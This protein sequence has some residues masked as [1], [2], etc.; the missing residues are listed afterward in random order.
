VEEAVKDELSPDEMAQLESSHSTPDEITP[1]QMA[2][3]D[4][5]HAAHP[6]ELT[7]EQ[8][9]QLSPDQPAPSDKPGEI[10][11]VHKAYDYLFKPEDGSTPVPEM[12][13]HAASLGF[14]KLVDGAKSISPADVVT[15]FITG[16]SDKIKDSMG[17][18]DGAATALMLP[19]TA[20][21]QQMMEQAFP[22][23]KNKAGLYADE[24]L[25]NEDTLRDTMKDV[26]EGS[27]VALK[28]V[29]TW[30]RGVGAVYEDPNR[31]RM[32]KF[33]TYATELEQGVAHAL[34][35]AASSIG[36]VPQEQAVKMLS[37]DELHMHDIVDYMFPNATGAGERTARF[38][39]GMGAD[40]FLDPVTYIGGFGAPALSK[41][42]GTPMVKF[43]ERM[44][45]DLSQLTIAERQ[46]LRAGLDVEKVLTTKGAMIAADHSPE[47]EH[48]SIVKNLELVDKYYAN[49]GGAFNFNDLH[50]ALTE[51][52][53]GLSN[54]AL[55][56]LSDIANKRFVSPSLAQE[57]INGEQVLKFSARIPMTNVG[58]EYHWPFLDQMV[59]QTFAK[60]KGG[61]DAIMESTGNFMAQQMGAPGQLALQIP[62][63]LQ[64]LLTD[65][66]RPLFNMARVMYKGGANQTAEELKAFGNKWYQGV[67]DPEHLKQ[68]QNALEVMPWSDNP[69]EVLHRFEKPTFVANEATDSHA[70]RQQ[71][72]AQKKEFTRTL[73]EG[74]NPF[75]PFDTG[76]I[77]RGQPVDLN[78]ARGKKSIEE[79]NKAYLEGRPSDVGNFTPIKPS[80]ELE[81]LQQRKAQA[82]EMLSTM[83]PEQNALFH[84]LRGKYRDMAMEARSRGLPFQELNPFGGQENAATGY[85]KHLV[86][87]EWID[88][89]G[90][91]EKAYEKLNQMMASGELGGQYDAGAL[92]R[93]ERR[94]IEAANAQ[95]RELHDIPVFSEDP[96][97]G[98][99]FRTREMD[100]MIRIHDL[101]ET[102]QPVMKFVEAAEES[103]GRGWTL[104]NPE[105]PKYGGVARDSKGNPTIAEG[106]NGGKGFFEFR[107]YLPNDI[108]NTLNRGGKV[109]LP[110][111]V[112][113]RMDFLIGKDNPLKTN[114][115]LKALGVFNSWFTPAALFGTGYLGKNFFANMTQ[116]MQAR[117]S[118]DHMVDA[119]KYLAKGPAEIL[120]FGEGASKMTMTGEEYTNI[121]TQHGLLQSSIANQGDSASKDIVDNVIEN[122]ATT[123]QP[124]ADYMKKLTTARDYIGLYGVQRR[125]AEY[126][127]S[128][129]KVA[130]FT[131]KLDEGYTIAGAAEATKMWFYDFNDASPGQQVGRTIFPF[132]THALKTTEQVGGQ[133]ANFNLNYVALPSKVKTI[134]EGTFVPD[135][136]VRSIYKSMTPEYAKDDIMG[137]MLPGGRQLVMEYPWAISTMKFLMDPQRNVH[138][139]FQMLGMAMSGWGQGEDPGPDQEMAQIGAPPNVNYL[140]KA[141]EFGA[142]SVLPPDILKA[143]T[144]YQLA[145]PQGE[146]F[147]D[148][149]KGWK[150]DP[151]FMAKPEL[152]MDNPGL[153]RFSNASNFAKWLDT[154]YGGNAVSNLFFH[155]TLDPNQGNPMAIQFRDGMYGNYVAAQMRQL[156]LGEARILPQDR[157]FF[158]RYGAMQRTYADL[159]RQ[160]QREQAAS[161]SAYIDPR[162]ML[163]PEVGN[164]I[165]AKGTEKQKE[166]MAQRLAIQSEATALKSF[167]GFMIKDKVESTG[168]IDALR[169]SLG[170]P[171]DPAMSKAARTLQPM[172]QGKASKNNLLQMMTQNP[173]PEEQM[174][175]SGE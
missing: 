109:F 5:H 110:E 65:S 131:Q 20:G 81:L 141:M 3:F 104:L 9:A 130:F 144:S 137:P 19:L 139:V 72:W 1:E 54:D 39:L 150:V 59:G 21:Y 7:H 57:L 105:D 111:D 121:L 82:E 96:I 76:E 159:T 175:G 12:V 98:H 140:Q 28:A 169:R 40:I 134:L 92:G 120:E 147:V 63:S 17:S 146:P 73:P 119:L 79:L 14:N 83:T 106:S 108:K 162:A 93:A 44:I 43:G 77:N 2:A 87:R 84:E 127:D 122:I 90:G 52:G 50:S 32:G 45:T 38:V 103:P 11:N 55:I 35:G 166:L 46:I 10:G 129:P 128:L 13:A 116:F 80:P 61:A 74:G 145:H 42:V 151:A 152:K 113:T 168:I 15:N 125:V 115:A 25:A 58:V 133:L 6:D 26:A 36:I 89:F 60:L 23:L 155:G 33:M 148:L 112:A 165:L 97:E 78:V 68:V 126:S 99:L 24:H 71:V 29:T 174:P 153:L 138:P 34:V 167:Y 31:S 114:Y 16:F 4:D 142:K 70:I 164:N 27:P 8:M 30:A 69:A 18:P 149:I 117:G 100:K 118:M 102:S 157:D 37:Q 53:S 173:S 86:S 56:G 123:R 107:N 154:S 91:G 124:R 62:K 94:T 136:S 48:Q 135:A 22:G 163:N 156:S 101:F 49:Q 172:L 64:L 67:P 158:L 132:T 170:A 47:L 143:M 75:N 51:K 161:T 88:R 171:L 85:V 66:S 95:S 160:L 41:D